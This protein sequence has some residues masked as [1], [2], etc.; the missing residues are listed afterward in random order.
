M[1]D[2]SAQAQRGFGPAIPS[3]SASVVLRPL[4]RDSV[5]INSGLLH[6]WQE[7]NRSASLPL[8]LRQLDTAGNLANLRLA[9][10][11]A[12]GEYRGPQ[13]MD[14]DLYKTLEAI[15]WEV[16]RSPRNRWPVSPRRQPNCWRPRSNPTAT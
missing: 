10:S 7:R 4:G 3:P 1:S 8:A 13:F 16:S 14:T 2:E 15:A 12:E 9:S 6:Q 11:H 5:T